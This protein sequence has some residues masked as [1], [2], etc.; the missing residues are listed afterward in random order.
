MTSKF[1]LVCEDDDIP[2]GGHSKI[3]HTFETD[4]LGVMLQ[5]FSHFL[6]KCGYLDDR[7]QL[8]LERVIDLDFGLDEYTEKLF[9][10]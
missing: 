3:S 9:N 4:E 7:K 1:K 8:T 10:E 2:F 6:K 5:N